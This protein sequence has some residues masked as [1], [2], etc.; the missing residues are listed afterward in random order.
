MRYLDTENEI[1]LPIREVDNRYSISNL[2]R[3]MNNKTGK[4]LKPWID[5]QGYHAIT[6]YFK[7]YTRKVLR[8]HRYVALYFCDGFNDGLI[9]NHIDGNK[10]NNRASNLEWVTCS[11][12][13]K[14]AY[15]IG[16]AKLTSSSFPER[17]V[18]CVE[19]NTQYKSISEASRITGVYHSN[20]SAVCRGKRKSAGG[21]T[22]KYIDTEGEK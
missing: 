19:T 4:I 11:E 14:H 1:W 3:V 5:N 9:V 16:L 15:R 2:G 12:N 17:S 18:M 10:L 6:F 21:Y 20:I 7:Q 22:W 13:I 8:V